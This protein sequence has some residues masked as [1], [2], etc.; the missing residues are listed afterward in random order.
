MESEGTGR[1]GGNC[2]ILTPEEWAKKYQG[3][4]FDDEECYT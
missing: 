3:I 4:D 1:N 2:N